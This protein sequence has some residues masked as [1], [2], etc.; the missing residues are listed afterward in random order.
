MYHVAKSSCLWHKHHIDIHF[1]EEHGRHCDGW[2]AVILSVVLGLADV[3][4]VHK[5]LHI[6]LKVWP[7]E[8][9]DQVALHRV[10]QG[11]YAGPPIPH[12]LHRFCGLSEYWTR[13][14]HGRVLVH[15]LLNRQSASE[16]SL[17]RIRANHVECMDSQ[18]KH[19]QTPYG[20]HTA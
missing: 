10:N 19:G 8:V 2:W 17:N 20:V 15:V 6:Q 3:A 12:G 7:P 16:L 18:T 14:L 13:T 1:T 4:R 11:L 9:L 5:P